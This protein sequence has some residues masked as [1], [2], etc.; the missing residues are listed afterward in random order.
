[1]FKKLVSLGVVN[2]VGAVLSFVSTIILSRNVSVEDF[3]VFGSVVTYA[4]I[5]SYF[6]ELGYPNSILSYTAKNKLNSHSE[7]AEIFRFYTKRVFALLIILIIVAFVYQKIFLPIYQIW[8]LIGYGFITAFIRVIQ[9]RYQS[10]GKIVA[11]NQIS[12]SIPSVRL[13]AVLI[14]VLLLDE[15]HGLYL[16]WFMVSFG[17]L[18]VLI[19]NQE[20]APDSSFINKAQFNAISKVFFINSIVT[21]LASRI[22]IVLGTK[23]ISNTELGYY[24]MAVTLSQIFPL[25]TNSVIQFFTGNFMKESRSSTLENYRRF[26]N[27]SI[28]GSLLVVFLVVVATDEVVLWLNP[29]YALAI[30]IFKALSV[31]HIIGVN[32]TPLEASLT[33]YF[34]KRILGLKISQLLLLCIVILSSAN[35]GVWA[36]VFAVGISRLAAWIFLIYYYVRNS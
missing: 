18:L 2:L 13:I 1:M 32:I 20:K 14:F 15:I 21:V 12:I 30:P 9:S 33:L 23:M 7:T 19:Y 24:F 17:Y 5:L 31:I 10:S 8:F 36:L 27:I 34:P 29:S 4:L 22:D 6:F 11:F 16:T 26:L 35:L 28:P 3:G 25:I